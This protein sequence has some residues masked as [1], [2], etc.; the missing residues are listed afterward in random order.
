MNKVKH[1]EYNYWTLYYRDTDELAMCLRSTSDENDMNQTILRKMLNDLVRRDVIKD[2]LP[3]LRKTDG[4]YPE[5]WDLCIAF[6][7]CP[8]IELSLDDKFLCTGGRAEYNSVDKWHWK[9]IKT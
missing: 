8:C 1:D 5:N 7:L 3:L 9:R 4:D 2:S 6:D